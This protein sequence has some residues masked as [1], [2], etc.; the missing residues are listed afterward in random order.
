MS[1]K[2]ASQ[3]AETVLS[4]FAPRRLFYLQSHAPGAPQ[5]YRNVPKTMMDNRQKDFLYNIFIE[6]I[7]VKKQKII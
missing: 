3:S 1:S 5:E 4:A 6:Q 2:A 7:F